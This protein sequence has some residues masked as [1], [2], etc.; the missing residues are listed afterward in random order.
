MRA[1]F[2]FLLSVLAF[3]C[4]ASVDTLFG[5]GQTKGSPGISL[6]EIDTTTGN[7]KL[8][9]TVKYE[10][11]AQELSCIDTKKSIYYIIGLNN[12]GKFKHPALLGFSLKSGGKLTVEV[13]LPFVELAFVGVSQAVEVDPVTSNVVLVGLDGTT[14]PP[15]HNVLLYNV[16]EKKLEEIVHIPGSGIAVLGASSTIDEAGVAYFTFALNNSGNVSE[17][18]FEV[19]TRGPKVGKY[20]VLQE[21]STHHLGTMD[22][23]AKT[24]KIYGLIGVDQGKWEMG[25]WNT[26]TRT[27]YTKPLVLG[28]TWTGGMASVQAFNSGSRTV[29]LLLQKGKPQKPFQPSTGCSPKCDGSLC[30]VDPAGG[31]PSCFEAKSCSQITPGGGR[32]N[33]TLPF[34]LAQFNIDTGSLVADPDLCTLSDCPWSL[35]SL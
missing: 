31:T 27:W 35:E 28:S 32:P 26:A 11:V 10:A 2:C 15:Y 16:K 9:Q 23:D 4:V 34:R 29:S 33:M 1:T 19:P 12:T 17:A 18:I 21:D 25:F 7:I 5:I 24:K 14:N 22:Y 6:Q 8:L 30:C 13:Q 3:Q 20:T